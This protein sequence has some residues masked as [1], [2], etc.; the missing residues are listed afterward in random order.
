MAERDRAP[1]RSQSAGRN[2]AL[3]LTISV[4]IL[5]WVAPLPPESR[6]FLLLLIA[7]GWLTAGVRW[8]YRRFGKVAIVV[9]TGIGLALG[10]AVGYAYWQDQSNRQLVARIKELHPFY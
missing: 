3:V 8:A 9:L 1:N 7:L 2:R 4:L 10:G 5:L 6:V